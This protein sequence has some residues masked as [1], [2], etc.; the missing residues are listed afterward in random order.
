MSS[1]S[2][3]P[4]LAPSE[5][6]F[7][8]QGLPH[9]VE[10]FS[11]SRATLSRTP[12]VLAALLQVQLLAEVAL[13]P[14]WRR[15]LIGW[16]AAVAAVGV[17][18]LVARALVARAPRGRAPRGRAPRGRALR[19]RA[20]RRL[21]GRTGAALVVFVGLGP[22]LALLLGAGGQP[23][24]VAALG[25]VA[26][27]GAG[28]LVAR[29][30]LV[31]VAGWTARRALH[32]LRELGPL[33]GRGLPL[34]VLFG[35]LTFFS[36]DLWRVAVSLSTPR[37]L[38]VVGFFQLLTVLFLLVMLPAELDRLPG[39]LSTDEIRAA[40]VGTPLAGALDRAGP[41]IRRPAL[42]AAHRLNMLVF[43]L[44]CQLIQVALLSTVVWVFFLVFGS[45]AVR[46]E[47]ITGWL[48]RGPQP[49]HL[50][51]AQLAGPSR[52]MLHVSTLLASLSAFYFTV[53]A[54]TDAVY[55]TAF[56][57]RTL[58][59]LTRS[60]AV[61]CCYLTVLAGARP[62]STTPPPRSDRDLPPP[63]AH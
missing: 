46:P 63:A 40:C 22:L 61:R 19:G 60:V 50:L 48:G 17:G 51:G 24:A 36:S 26:L 53:S 2:G 14:S 34:L 4:P 54:V 45:V 16:L 59:E 56:F 38:L 18:S 37:L 12:G 7:V 21:R 9:F 39:E 15:R 1:S 58:A 47:V 6:W 49:A 20:L 13:A 3:P 55:R 5:Q 57:S 10:G 43:L 35:V 42:T 11:P 31:S 62:T 33:A 41:P 8:R 25:N 32:E 23:V 29:F 52:D 44:L 28:Y 30:A 27:A